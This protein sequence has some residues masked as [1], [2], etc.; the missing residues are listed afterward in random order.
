MNSH[1][2][3]DEDENENLSA[4]SLPLHPKICFESSQKFRFRSMIA[5]GNPIV[6]ISAEITEDIIPKYGLKWGETIF[7]NESNVGF[8]KELESNPKVKYIPG[9]SIQNTLR[10]TSWCINM[11]QENHKIFKIT[12]LGATGKDSYRKKILDAFALAG[13]NGLLECIEDK[14]T[15]R[16]GVGIHNKE[17]CLLP[18]IRASNQISDRFI[19]EHDE[20]IMKHD[21]LLIEGYF[22]QERFEICKRLMVKFKNARKIVILTLS[23]VFMVENYYDKLIEL[24]N[25]SDLIVANMSE[26]QALAKEKD[27]EYKLVFSKISQMLIK[28]DRLFVVT[29][30]KKGAVVAKYDYNR[31]S[32]DFILKGFPSL[33]KTEDIVDLNG[34]GDSFLGGFLSQYM[35]GKSFEAC[36][37]AGNDIAGVIIKNIGCTFPKHLKVKFKD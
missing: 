24:A 7:A 13:V 18:E 20:E 17:R 15:S 6:D 23:A 29:D 28:K 3:E 8:F 21:A 12:M 9:G 11:N 33:V 19:R 34:A 26:L 25:Y 32:M 30:G 5:I 37:K 4:F 10:T 2:I 27:A 36:C 22:I 35:Q 31:A 16:C 1:E 14:Q